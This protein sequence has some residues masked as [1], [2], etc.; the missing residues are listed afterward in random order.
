MTLRGPLG[1]VRVTGR[2][3]RVAVLLVGV[4]LAA[5]PGVPADAQV[6]QIAVRTTKKG[7]FQ[8]ARTT[9]ALA[10]EQNTRRHPNHYDVMVQPDGGSPQRVNRRRFSA[11]MGD[12][13]G[14]GLIYQEYRGKPATRKGRSD[15]WFYNTNSRNRSR[16][17]KVNSRHWEYWPSTSGSWLLFGRTTRNDAG[18]LYLY[19]LDTGIRRLLDKTKPGDSSI[20]P[21]QVN[22]NFAVWSKCTK[23][24]QVYLYDIAARDR[25]KIQ[26]RGTN[27]RAPSVTAGGTVYFSR[28]GAG[29]G[30]SVELVRARPDGSQDVL[31]NLQSVLDIRDTYVYTE[32]NGTVEVY[33]ERNG[34]GKP[35]ASD[36]YKIR[37]TEVAT[38]TVSAAGQGTVSSSPPGVFCRP[39]CSVDFERNTVVTLT[40]APASGHVFVGWTGACSGAG[41]CQIT[42]DAAKQVGATFLPVG[43]IMI[44]KDA[45]PDDPADFQ[46]QTDFFLGPFALD[47][48]PGSGTPNSRLFTPPG[49]DGDYQA[50]EVAPP[51]GWSLTA[52]ACLDPDGDS[53]GNVGS[54]TA[55]IDLGAAEAVLCAFV[56]TRS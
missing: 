26:N 21:G 16:M 40:A 55:F 8:P 7:E 48:D 38:L 18:R 56:N 54:R 29:C 53:F 11:A 17:G 4:M 2:L 9:G 25:R 20:G 46:F 13:T 41:S 34:C 24:C 1:S 31:V 6:A 10:W 12:F 22:A 39:D 47:D 32:P 36:L 19:N 33:Y 37:D 3:P 28:G 5:L 52:I 45:V 15:I 42:M 14:N 49:G 23:R 27:Q 43:S 51:S 44:V 30:Q 50:Q 35:A